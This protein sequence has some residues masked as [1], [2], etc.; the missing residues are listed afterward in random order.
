MS[1]LGANGLHSDFL[2]HWHPVESKSEGS[3]S[4]QKQ[5]Q[6]W[7]AMLKLKNHQTLGNTVETKM[8]MQ[9]P[10]P[11]DPTI[12]GSSHAREA[13]S[14]PRLRKHSHSRQRLWG[15]R[16]R[17]DQNLSGVERSWTD[18][19]NTCP[20]CNCL[21]WLWIKL[22][23]F[24]QNVCKVRGTKPPCDIEKTAIPYWQSYMNRQWATVLNQLVIDR[25]SL[26][27]RSLVDNPSSLINH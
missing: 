24:E 11:Y 5:L 2:F 1:A 25:Y 21:G 20:V 8:L 13:P 19:K 17:G 7:N 18:T 10:I 12:P 4:V 6:P 3:A 27:F 22:L 14:P 26:L 15:G 9:L 16:P 23:G